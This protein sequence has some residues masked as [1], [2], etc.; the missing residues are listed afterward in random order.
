MNNYIMYVV[1][2][3]TSIYLIVRLI[4]HL[5]EFFMFM[6]IKESLLMEVYNLL[7]ISDDN[8]SMDLDD[9]LIKLYAKVDQVKGKKFVDKLELQY[10]DNDN[11]LLSLTMDNGKS[12]PKFDFNVKLGDIINIK[13]VS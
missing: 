6:K 9:L 12:K 10:V 5:V 8:R 2:L 11:M 1:V 13:E 7:S 3:S 4:I